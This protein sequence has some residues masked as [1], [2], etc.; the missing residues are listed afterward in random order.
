MNSSQN[1][2]Y[3]AMWFQARKAFGIGDR[4][5]VGLLNKSTDEINWFEF[6]HSE[7]DGLGGLSTILR[8]HDYPCLELPKIAEK[9]TP[10]H[11]QQVK[12]LF[13]GGKSDGPKQIRWKT[14]FPDYALTNLANTDCSTQYTN[15]APIVNAHFS[16]AETLEVKKLAR[17]HRVALNI[18]LFWAL[19]RAVAAQLLASQQDYYWLYPVNLRGALPH[20]PETGNCSSGVNVLLNNTIAPR[21]IQL[22]VKQQIKAKSHWQ[23]WWQA[24]IGKII[25]E[26][27]V[28]RI[29]QYVSERQFY[30]GSFSFLG[31]WPLKDD[32]NPP[33]N[34]DELWVCCGIGTKN[35]PVSTGILLWHEQLSLGLKLHPYI[36]DDII[37]TQSVMQCWKQHLLQGDLLVSAETATSP[38]HDLNH[39]V[40]NTAEKTNVTESMSVTEGT[41]KSAVIELAPNSKMK[42]NKPIKPSKLKQFLLPKIEQGTQQT[43]DTLRPYW[44]RGKRLFIRHKKVS[45]PLSII[46]LTFI[47]MTLLSVI[48]PQSQV[49]PEINR[50]PSVRYMDVAFDNAI[51]PIFSRGIV[52]AKTQISLN[53]EVTARVKSVAD[54]F[55]AGGYFNAGDVLLSMDD[56]AYQLEVIKKKQAVDGALLHL[57]EAKAKAHVARR[58]VS[59]KATRFARHIPQINDA[60]SRVKAAEADLRLANIKV[61]RSVIKAPFSGRVKTV[62]V[63]QGQLVNS[64]EIIGEIYS[65]DKMHVRLPV[66][67]KYLTLMD[68]PFKV[69]AFSHDKKTLTAVDATTGKNTRVTLS[70]NVND[71]KY[72]WQGLITGTEGGLAENR[73]QYVVA[74]VLNDPEQPLYLQPGRFVTAEIAGREFENVVIIPRLALRN[75]NK[76]WLLD[77]EKRLRIVMVDI[78]HQ[79][80]EQVYITGGLSAGDKLILTP[81]DV[82][83]DGMKLN[84][85]GLE[86]DLGLENALND[87]ISPSEVRS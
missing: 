58:G 40:S 66:A 23:L 38:S 2:D 43:K 29:Y 49:N 14:T 80:K 75:D 45:T 50:F 34:P 22:Q 1:K 17:K 73:L 67:D 64:G 20:V 76:V 15:D 65:L 7:M 32:N 5:S 69:S 52:A 72:Q 35:Y 39:A 46:A 44:Q 78:L 4:M 51:I 33:V 24:H 9:S 10:S 13:A 41:S 79:G 48:R 71:K 84:V 12:M 63:G 3:I 59:S 55:T 21:D 25:G 26:K 74:E 77:S 61:E 31:N 60:K 30:A 87:I 54:T 57:A 85:I 82:A 11:W 62:N 56:E 86:L 16:Q 37:K 28:R 53:S 47:C 27:G 8:E 19:N 81:L 36:A 18:Y 70:V 6:A 68:L 42:S 83:V